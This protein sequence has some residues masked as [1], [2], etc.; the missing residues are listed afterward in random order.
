MPTNNHHPQFPGFIRPTTTP[1]PDEV[2]DILME[3]LSHAELRVLL[4]IVRRTFGFKKE[5]DNISLSQ[6]VNGIKTKQGKILDGGTGLSKS[7]V[8][9]ALVG[10]REKGVII[11]K[12]NS[13]PGKG[14]EP[15]TYALRF[16]SD[17]VSSLWTGGIHGG[18][19]GGVHGEGQGP[20][21]N[22]DT[23][24]TVI[25][26]TVNKNDDVVKS[27]LKIFGISPAT[28]EKFS[29]E[30]PEE[31]LAGKLSWAEWLLSKGE[32]GKDGKQ[33][34]WLSAAIKGDYKPGGD[35]ETPSTRKARTAKETELAEAQ[36]E[37]RRKS[38]QEFKLA[39]EEIQRSIR[40]NHPPEPVGKEGL[41][42]ESAWTLTLEKM[43]SELSAGM[44]QT[45]LKNTMLVSI[46]GKT[47]NVVVPNQLTADW[48]ER[49][50]YQ[51][52]NRAFTD[53]I[54]QDVDFRFIPAAIPQL[55]AS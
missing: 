23:Q 38:E 36:A 34:G 37:S 21:H 55:A 16:L 44:F 25:Q 2:F 14:D 41:T 17:P 31:Y 26:E 27:Q 50:L 13:S 48:I 33:A 24:Q 43:E 28:A 22:V 47:A 4:Y 54:G 15:T 20:V 30:Y 40:E 1:V 9:K 10:L 51:T 11:S 6:M 35:Y 53:I 7:G 5:K 42:T 29:R 32:I 45:W 3:Q 49:R 12:R 18:G 8:A 46:E 39:Q 19:Q 52:L